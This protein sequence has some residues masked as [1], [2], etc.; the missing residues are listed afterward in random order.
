MTTKYNVCFHY[1]CVTCGK[2]DTDKQQSERKRPDEVIRLIRCKQC[3]ER[4]I[5]LPKA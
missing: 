2:R 3:T 5:P 4:G 1:E